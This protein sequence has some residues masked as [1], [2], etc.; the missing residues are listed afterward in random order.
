ME[1][2]PFKLS[3]FEYFYALEDIEFVL[4]WIISA[5]YCPVTGAARNHHCCLTDTIV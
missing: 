2:W 4:L 5:V 1:L 3:Q